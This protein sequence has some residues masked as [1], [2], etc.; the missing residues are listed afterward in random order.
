MESDHQRAGDGEGHD[1]P[2]QL[3]RTTPQLAIAGHALEAL[4]RLR[5]GW[6]GVRGPILPHDFDDD[7]AELTFTGRGFRILMAAQGRRLG[8][9][10]LPAAA[11]TQPLTLPNRLPDTRST[12]C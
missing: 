11:L 8:R 3:D 7:A 5:E 2:E 12:R 9:T 4:R 10:V 6:S 1:R